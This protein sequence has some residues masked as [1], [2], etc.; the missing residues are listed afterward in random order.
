MFPALGFG[1]KLP[2]GT[3]SHEFFLVSFKFVFW[4]DFLCALCAVLTLIVFLI[5][6]L[7]NWL[8]YWYTQLND[9]GWHFIYYLSFGRVYVFACRTV[10]LRIRTVRE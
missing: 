1:A 3:V 6:C 5:T 4:G 2:N 8:H 9:Y 10:I 7:C